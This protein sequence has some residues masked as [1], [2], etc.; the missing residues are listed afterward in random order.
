M[1]Y[2][3]NAVPFNVI[4]FLTVFLDGAL[5]YMVHYA[6]EVKGQCNKRYSNTVFCN[7]AA[8]LCVLLFTELLCMY[9]ENSV[10]SLVK[11]LFP[12]ILGTIKR[13]DSLHTHFFFTGCT[14]Y[15]FS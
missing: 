4:Q 10:E 14:V 13:G 11:A 9:T 15:M 3:K 7:A 1:V 5:L 12:I 8:F 2:Q 6:K